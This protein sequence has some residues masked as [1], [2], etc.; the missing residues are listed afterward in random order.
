MSRAGYNDDCEQWALICWRGAVNSAI[1]GARGQAFLNDLIAALDALPEKKLIAEELE[2]E[3]TV[4]AI[5][6]VGRARGLDMSELDPQEPERV[7]ST[8][9]IASA[10]A[11]EITYVNDECGRRNETPEE[12]FARM[13]KWAVDEIWNARGCV[14]DPYGKHALRMSRR[15][16]YRAAIDWNEV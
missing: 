16:H 8:F 1:R 3:G 15:L 14:A 12:R 10:M 7:A 5:G 2:N 13:R 9:G 6:A 4:C 11:R